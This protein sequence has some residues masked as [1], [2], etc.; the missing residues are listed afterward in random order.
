MNKNSV[1]TEKEKEKQ[2]EKE[3]LTQE[4]PA[5][6]KSIGC[7]K[8]FTV[9]A[10]WL[11]TFFPSRGQLIFNMHIEKDEDGFIYIVIKKEKNSFNGLGGEQKK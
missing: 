10:H 7:S 8:G 5:S 9:P 3:V 1:E 11:K 4:E 2:Q 6:L